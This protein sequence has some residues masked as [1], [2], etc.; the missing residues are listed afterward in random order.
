MTEKFR[1]DLN[2]NEPRG[3]ATPAP[4]S[5]VPQTFSPYTSHREIPHECGDACLPGSGDPDSFNPDTGGFDHI[6]IR[7]T[8]P[9]ED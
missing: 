1:P 3:A 6:V 8:G 4:D 7:S 2:P 5:A 9:T